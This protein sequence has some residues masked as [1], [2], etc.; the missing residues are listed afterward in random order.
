MLFVSSGNVATVAT[1]QG[2]LCVAYVR[3]RQLV[4]RIN[5]AKTHLLI[6]SSSRRQLPW[7]PEVPAEVRHSPAALPAKY[8]REQ[9]GRRFVAFTGR[10]RQQAIGLVVADEL[11]LDRDPTPVRGRAAT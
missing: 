2:A 7:R 6:L 9:L 4:I 5:S 1:R 11:F 10:A 3:I 8:Y